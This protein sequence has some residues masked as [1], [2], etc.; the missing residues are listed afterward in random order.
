[1]AV[2]VFYNPYLARASSDTRCKRKIT[3]GTTF[4][5]IVPRGVMRDGETGL[6][7]HMT[8][9][10]PRMFYR[11]EPYIVS[12]D[13]SWPGMFNRYTASGVAPT[14]FKF[15][16][17]DQ[18][19]STV[20]GDTMEGVHSRYRHHIVPSGTVL[21]FFGVMEDNATICVNVF[22]QCGYFYCEYHDSGE[23][24]N[25]LAAAAESFSDPGKY[26][27]SVKRVNRTSIYGYNTNYVVGLHLVS[28]GDWGLARKVSQRL[29]DA[30]V[31]VYE[32]GVD[33]LT[34]FLIDR[35]VPSFGWCEVRKC[36]VRRYGC[37]STCDVEVDCDVGDVFAIPEDMSWPEYRGVSFDIECMS[38]NGGFPVP[39][40]P[41]DIIIQI[42]CVCYVVGKGDASVTSMDGKMSVCEYHLFNVGPCGP[43]DDVAVYE[44]PSELEMLLGFFTFFKLYAP[45]FVTGY[46]INAFDLK[47]ILTRMNKIY[48]VSVDNYTKL[49][50]GG[51]FSVYSPESR[52]KHFAST[53]HLKV[54]V[55]GSIVL[56]MYPVCVAKTSSQNYKLD[57]V[58]RLYLGQTKDDMSYKDIPIY[59]SRS[60][61]GRAKVGKYCVQ[62]AAL[63]R[64]LFKKIS[65]HYEAAAVARLARIPMRRVI[66]D[67]QQIR[68]FTCILEE[69]GARGMV[70]P[71]LKK[72]N[73]SDAEDDVGGVR[74]QGATVLEP[75]VGYYDTPVAV[76]DFASLYPS[77]IMANNLCYS[78]LLM[79]G[80]DVADKDVLKVN[81]SDGVTHRFVRE[82]VRP[83][84]L[85]E[86]LARWVAQRRLVR[87]A[88]ATCED[89]MTKMLMDK[90]QVALKVTCNAFYGFT[91]VDSGM[92]PCLPIA[93]SIT[94]IGRTMLSDASDYIHSMF[95]DE[96]FVS[97]YFSEDDFTRDRVFRVEVI[98]GD[99]DS[100]F[101]L[102]EGVN[103][104]ALSREVAAMARHI[105]ETLFRYPV[106]L[107]FEKLFASLMMICK[108]R[109]IG[110]VVGSK[111]LVMKGVELVRRTTCEFVKC[112]VRD[113]LDMLFNDDEVVRSAV[114]LSKMSEDRLKHYGVPMGFYKILTRLC[115]ARDELYLNTVDVTKLSLSS[116][117]SQDVSCYK[118]KN[119]PHLAVIKRL[120]S[121]SEELPSVGDRILYVLVAPPANAR[122]NI[123]NYELAEDP[124]YVKEKNIPINA[125][126][127]F[128]HVIKAVTNV[129][130][131]VFPKYVE[132]KEKFLYSIMPM[133]VYVDK[134]F[135]PYCCSIDAYAQTE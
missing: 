99:T 19:E 7:K 92:M 22:G 10:S 45:E 118:Q 66:F 34:R 93:A 54:N 78:T 23:L 28:F 57:T 17:Y 31:S 16:T 26:S 113:I 37:A 117:L 43:I 69:A 3:A 29:F 12:K 127:Y 36:H 134:E 44:F 116:V 107:E 114:E 24:R 133:R 108:K 119:L 123:P 88:M 132:K 38:G 81:I 39:E 82:N 76:F 52:Q 125:G 112:V 40:N 91:G 5:R 14:S 48:N 71:N 87:D 105:T 131:P 67:G 55:T 32:M 126:K 83:S 115:S 85:G 15:H 8:N 18:V 121:R 63:V 21:R 129:M 33:P 89:P 1:M 84:I 41:D 47:Y 6:I 58:A 56:D 79:N 35:K 100:M 53:S 59:Y 27:F 61:E 2:P 75:R 25:M 97:R 73:A 90:Q 30:G 135:L 122:K 120:A 86:L 9:D 104:S 68:I 77:I 106:K 60:D 109:Y 96:V 42:S 49:N 74:Y 111:V 102:F 62:D 80:N 20:Y 130:C 64:D 65:Y 70:L 4:L 124:A 13:M 95:K 50:T 101:V 46:N 51:R 98:Y 72:K 103:E 110:R 128:D 11:D 94:R